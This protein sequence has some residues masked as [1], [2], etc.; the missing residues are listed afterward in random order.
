MLFTENRPVQGED[1]EKRRTGDRI[2]G[3]PALRR[4]SSQELNIGRIVLIER[5]GIWCGIL[6]QCIHDGFGLHRFKSSFPAANTPS[7][8]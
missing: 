8:S 7:G 5:T 1:H 4:R 3:G 6:Q 2:G